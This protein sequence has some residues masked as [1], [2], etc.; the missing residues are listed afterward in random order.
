MAR[1]TDVKEFKNLRFIKHPV[2]G[3]DN[4]AQCEFPN[5]YGL[6][7]VNGEYACCKK[8]TY[9]VGILHN[10]E[11]TYNTPLTDDVLPDVSPER[12]DE[13]IA[14]VKSWKKDQY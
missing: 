5:G 14:T 7:V 1:Q 12:I 11:L 10:G 6:S 8:D 13:L 3:F 9:E 4:I 2:N